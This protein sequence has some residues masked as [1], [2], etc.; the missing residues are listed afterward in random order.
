MAVAIRTI[1]RLQDADDVNVTLG[2]GV[3]TTE[4]LFNGAIE[5]VLFSPGSG[6]TQPSDDWDAVLTDDQCRHGDQRG[7]ADCSHGRHGPA[8]GRAGLGG[9]C[10]LQ[11]RGAAGHMDA[12]WQ[13][14]RH[15]GRRRCD[16]GGGRGDTVLLVHPDLGRSR[17]CGGVSQHIQHIKR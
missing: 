8:D 7:G 10:T 4:E 2:A 12:D 13:R 14:R 16:L 6:D 9:Q 3:D 5:Q 1:T 17:R 15:C 11:V